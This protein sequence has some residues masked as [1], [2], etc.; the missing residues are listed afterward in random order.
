[1]SEI[2]IWPVFTC[3]LAELIC[4]TSVIYMKFGLYVIYNH[5]GIPIVNTEEIFSD[6]R[7]FGL[8]IKPVNI[9]VP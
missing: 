9:N 2:N 3:G 7:L 1:M 6:S 8:N 5:R 4:A